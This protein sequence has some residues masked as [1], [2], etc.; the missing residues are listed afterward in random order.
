[1]LRVNTLLR[2]FSG[3]ERGHIKKAALFSA[4][5]SAF[6]AYYSY[7]NYRAKDFNR[8]HAN[9]RLSETP[10]NGTPVF[11]M[12][13]TWYR[14]PWQ[15]YQMYHRF[16]PYFVQGHIDYEKEILI[17][18]TRWV[19]GRPVL[20]CDVY[21]PFYCFDDGRMHNVFPSFIF[22]RMQKKKKKPTKK[23]QIMSP[24]EDP[25]RTLRPSELKEYRQTFK[26]FDV[27]N[28]E[29]ITLDELENIL[30]SMGQRPTREELVELM[31]EADLDGNGSIDEHEFLIMMANRK[32]DM[33]DEK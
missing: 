19:N 18:R 30:R 9:F 28:D 27:N 32:K 17:P 16:K 11:H 15:D 4:V 13:K 29:T 2:S 26:V 7:R 6:S 12:F 14:M 20:G 21:N 5:A 8:M 33:N 31:N 3:R 22:Q 24:D 23:K 10:M 1:M 25:S